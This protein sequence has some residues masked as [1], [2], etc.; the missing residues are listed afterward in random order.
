MIYF[1]ISVKG[2]D[3]ICLVKQQNREKFVEVWFDKIVTSANTIVELLPGI[4]LKPEGR[5]SFNYN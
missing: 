3:A 2:Q 5:Y 1:L 4:N